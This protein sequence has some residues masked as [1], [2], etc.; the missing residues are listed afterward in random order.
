[1][2][3]MTE[4]RAVAERLEITLRVPLERRL[5]G[6]EKV[7]EHKTSMLQD[8][9]A[10]RSLEVDAIVSS[11]IEIGRRLGVATP[12]IEAVYACV[13]LLDERLAGG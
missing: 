8:V 4:A 2:E 1:M 9:E 6:A 12:R 3:L 13:K 10:G 7:G 11:V 5:D